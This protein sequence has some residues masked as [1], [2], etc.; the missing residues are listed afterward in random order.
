ML[1]NFKGVNMNK[2]LNLKLTFAKYVSLNI[3]GMIGISLYILADTFFIA[4]GIGAVGLA[5]LNIAIPVYNFLHGTGLMIG[6]GGATRFSISRSENAFTQAL[7]C[8]AIAVC[9]FLSLSIFLEPIMRIMGANSETLESAVIYNRVLLSFSPMFLFNNCLIC[10][11]RNDGNPRLAMLSMLIGSFA[12]IV[13]D[14][15]FIF[16][17]KMGMFGAALATGF[18]PIIS[19]AILSL[20]FIKGRNTFHISKQG[21]RPKV[22]ADIAALG[23]PSLITEFSSGIVIIVFNISILR[24]LGNIGVAAYGVLANIALVVIAVFNGISQGI[25]P[26]ISS[27][28]GTGKS[29]NAVSVLK[30]GIITAVTVSAIIYAAAFVF[31]KTIVAAFNRDND[32]ALAEIAEHGMRIYFSAFIFAGINI[33][34]ATFFSSIDKPKKAFIVSSLRGFIIIIPA[35]FV[36]AAFFGINGVWLSMTVTE[37]IVLLPVFIMMRRSL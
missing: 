5:A 8:V 4:R 20:H 28:Y 22:M 37:L 12:N 13:F 25:Q 24:I 3:I 34:S 9:L 2:N 27:S 16:P 17:F 31:A 7:Y 23:V 19:I 32:I 35:I 6:M 18:A 14:Y 29:K 15:I 30:Y 36:M 11:V 21:I 1:L 10:F 33:L 26:I